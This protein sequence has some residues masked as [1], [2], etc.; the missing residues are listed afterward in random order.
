MVHV[1]AQPL[2]ME[3]SL[4]QSIDKQSKH[5]LPKLNYHLRASFFFDMSYTHRP[6]SKILECKVPSLHRKQPMQTH[7]PETLISSHS[8]IITFQRDA[9]RVLAPLNG[10]TNF[11]PRPK[12]FIRPFTV[13]G[14]EET[15]SNDESSENALTRGSRNWVT[16]FNFNP[17]SPM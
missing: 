7:L 17:S 8:R 1:N 5:Q 10:P 9:L 16:L 2:K 6:T 14:E 11:S 15:F 13:A 12:M 4:V 3:I